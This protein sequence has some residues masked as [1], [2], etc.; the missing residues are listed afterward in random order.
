VATTTDFGLPGALPERDRLALRRWLLASIIAV[1]FAVAVGGI[2]RLT[3]SGL[4]IT[5]WKP[6]S[7]ALPPSS[8]AA[9]ALELEKFRQI[10]QASTTHAGI[11]LAQFKWIYW[12]EWFHR[13]VARTV[14]LVFAIPYLVFLV[15][16]RLP[17]A[18]R[19]RLT[20]L[21]LL[22]AGQGALGWYMVQSGLVERISVSA[23]RLTAHLGLALGILAVAV[24]TYSELRARTAEELQE[25]TRTSPAWRL[26]LVSATT[27]LAIT[28]LSGGFVA[29][30]RGG[31]VFNEFPLMGGQVV[32]PGYATLTPWWSNAFENPAAAQFHHRVLALTVT[33]LVL[34]LAWRT[35]QASLPQSVKRA[36]AGFATVITVQLVLGVTTLL[37]A[38]PIP[39]GVLHQFTGVLALTAA[40]VAT[41]RAVAT[42]GEIPAERRIG[43]RQTADGS[44]YSAQT[45]VG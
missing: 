8:D 42:V 9:W 36:V 26:A 33:A 40:L 31:K 15:Q 16:G 21:P 24:W 3:E 1:F 19:L 23:Y 12:W 34:T 5:E 30:L 14:G 4:S 38:V 18:L 27:L 43:E 37:L 41:Q 35:R 32:P 29:G 39:L 13:N 2:T 45:A 20:A 28:V 10:P 11:S 7:G 44:H 22:T 17:K 6:V 25:G